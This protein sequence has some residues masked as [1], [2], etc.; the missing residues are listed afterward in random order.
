MY[1]DEHG[2]K[3]WKGN[4]HTHTT[5][6]DGRLSPDDCIALYRAHGYD[7][8]AL[9]DHWKLSENAVSDNGM[10]L[11]AGC[12]YDFGRRVQEGIYHVV[13]IGCERD[14]LVTRE[15]G[16]RG[17]IEKIHTAGGLADLAHPAWSMN[18]LDQLLPLD[19][20]ADFTEIFNSVSDLPANCRPYS[21]E[22]VDLLASRGAVW[23]TAAVDDT[24]WYRRD[25]CR[26][27]VWVRA[28]ACTREAILAAIR[29]GDF[30]STEGPRMAVTLDGAANCVRV[31]C[32]A[33]DRVAMVTYF[34]DTAWTGHR[35]DVGEDLTDAAFPLTGRETFVR[36]E[37]RDADGRCGW[38]QT[39]RIQDAE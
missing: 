15:D 18:T 6:S 22:I 31:R 10:L 1:T 24:H 36:V 35:S 7:F 37:V 23:K 29:A 34:T 5:R 28:E 16:A 13:A 3:W 20:L 38:G 33:E 2:C 39:V 4:L 9:T 8:L 26:A 14:P 11:F 30:Y 17:A 25:A 27:Y 32:P 12:E 21:G 19:G